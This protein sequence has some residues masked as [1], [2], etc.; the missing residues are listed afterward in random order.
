M[1]N[2]Q[3]QQWINTRK[4]KNNYENNHNRISNQ[5]PC[6]YKLDKGNSKS[7]QVNT[8]LDELEDRYSDVSIIESKIIGEQNDGKEE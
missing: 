2:C 5:S 1:S 6:S 3:K 7:E 8:L 4:K